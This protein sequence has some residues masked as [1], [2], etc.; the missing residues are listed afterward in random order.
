VLTLPNNVDQDKIDVVCKDGVLLEMLPKAEKT[1][2]VK[3]KVKG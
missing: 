2:P 1:K 3:I